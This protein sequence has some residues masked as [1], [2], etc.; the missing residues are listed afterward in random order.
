MEKPHKEAIF[1]AKH[2]YPHHPRMALTSNFFYAY[3]FKLKAFF[4]NSVAVVGTKRTIKQSYQSDPRDSN[5]AD[6]E[7]GI[8]LI[9][10]F[11]F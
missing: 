5:S 3:Y 6:V 1:L 7:N 2:C 10:W 8:N 4:T 11:T 9:F